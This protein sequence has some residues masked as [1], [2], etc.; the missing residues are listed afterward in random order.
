MVEAQIGNLCLNVLIDSG[1]MRS[2]ISFGHSQDMRRGDPKLQLLETNLKCVTASG[3]S[4]DIVG[5]VRVTFKIHG[6][7]WKWKMLVSKG[8]RSHTILGVDF[9]SK[10]K[11]ILDLGS[12]QCYFAFAPSVIIKFCQHENYRLC[13]RTCQLS[14]RPSQVQTGKLPAGQQASL[15]NLIRQYPDVLSEKLG[16]THLLD[17]DIQ[18]TDTKPV[19]LS[20]YRL[21]P[22]KMK[23]LREHIKTL[24][25]EGVIEPSLSNYSSPI[26]LVPK[27]GGAYRAVVDFRMLNKRISIESVPLPDIHSAFNWFGK[28]KFFTTLDLNQA[29]HQIPLSKASKPLTAFCTDWNLYQYTRVPF[30]LATGA[31]VLSRLLDRVFQ[32]IKFEF[33]YHYLDDVAIYSESFEEHLEHI[34]LVLERLRQA[35]L[36]VKPQKVVFATQEI[37]FLGHLVSPGCVRIDPEWTKPIR[38]FPVP[39]DARGIARFVGM[40][41]F[42]HKFIPNFAD[43]AAPLNALRRKGMKFVWGPEQQESFEALKRAVSQPPVLGMANFADKFI[44][45]TDDSGVALGA[46][47]SQ[48]CNGFRQPIAFAFRTLSAQERK[49][50][51]TYELECLAVLF[52]TENFRKYIEHQDFILETDNQALS[53]LLAHPRQLGKIGR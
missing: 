12:H 21:S 28:A 13:S 1:S 31:Q 17:Y 27:T 24:F 34:R 6:F 3:E 19:R 26:F 33:V 52:G 38:D 20:P 36:T 40:V 49:A 7:S 15:E 22:P 29:Y 8:L 42:Y 16:L 50:S 18:L 32:D 48:E 23:Y 45:Q 5:E 44:L 41:N 25:S 39:R 11:M 37:S 30:G 14:A 2:V 47:L 10:T 46:V 35:G 53:W 51:C 4:L 9:I 43:T